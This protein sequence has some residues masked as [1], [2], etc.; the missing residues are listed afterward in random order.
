MIAPFV[1]WR[2]GV[3]DIN[4][5]NQVAIYPN[6]ATDNIYISLQHAPLEGMIQLFDNVGNVVMQQPV[7]Q[8]QTLNISHLPAGMYYL[9]V[10]N[11]Q[12][13]ISKL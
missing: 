9:K 2:T 1:N 12:Y 8:Q 7:Q 11:K 4:A 10:E 13:K 5:A 6:P 3:D